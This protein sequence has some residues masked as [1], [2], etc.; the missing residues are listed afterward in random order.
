MPQTYM[1]NMLHYQILVF[2]LFFFQRMTW[3]TALVSKQDIFL[4]KFDSIAT[5]G[6]SSDDNFLCERNHCLRVSA[7]VDYGTIRVPAHETYDALSH[8]TYQHYVLYVIT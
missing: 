2:H 6:A 8:V 3:E 7:P 4:K 5:S 1:I